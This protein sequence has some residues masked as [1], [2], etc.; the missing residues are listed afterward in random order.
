MD[1]NRAPESPSVVVG[2]DGTT[3]ALRAVEWA[4]T[5]ARHRGVPL[6]IVHAAPYAATAADTRHA[7]AI[8]ARAFTAA[9]HHEPTIAAHT[10][11]L[12]EQPVPALV[13]AGAEAALL[14]LGMVGR[15]LGEVVLGS[16]AAAVTD[17]VRCPVTVVPGHYR[18]PSTDGPVVLGLDDVA[19]NA[20]AITAAFT[21]AERHGTPLV[22]MH[23]RH[24]R[25][26]GAETEIAHH[27]D[28]QLGPWRARHPGVQ[29]TVDV[30]P[31]P[32][33]EELMR[34]GSTARLLVV[35][36]HSRGAASRAVLGSCSRTLLRHSPCPLTIV[37][38]DTRPA[39]VAPGPATE[40]AT[41]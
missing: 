20:A 11:R 9:R 16:V 22:A 41:R 12:D 33:A 28:E 35:G 38:H 13:N 6:R 2:T 40:R 25:R 24:G 1:E 26:T 10:S 4:A 8:L 15:G 31:G 29:V 39:G 3:T 7:T 30:R 5:E 14:V 21:D 27:L 32:P 18:A 34:A 36:A 17:R 23:S 37:R 19:V